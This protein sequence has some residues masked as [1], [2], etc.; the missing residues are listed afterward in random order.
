[1]VEIAA[2]NIETILD[3]MDDFEYI[4]KFL[5]KLKGKNLALDF[6]R[7]RTILLDLEKRYEVEK[8]TF[9]SNIQT[10]LP[11]LKAQKAE[12]EDLTN[13]LQRYTDSRYE[14]ETF[15]TL[16]AFR[17][18]EIETAEFIIYNDKLKNNKV[19]ET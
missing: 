16:L 19:I 12:P 3:I 10:L 8:S 6:Q 13:L 15:N 9:T 18:K 1:M 5:R 4:E 7:Y 14:K 2:G 11:K 17:Q